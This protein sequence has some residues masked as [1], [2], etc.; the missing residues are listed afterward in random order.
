[1]SRRCILA[2][3]AAWLFPSMPPS[4]ALGAPALASPEPCGSAAPEAPHDLPGAFA[5][6]LDSPTVLHFLTLLAKAPPATQKRVFAAAVAAASTAPEKSAQAA[7]SAGCPDLD[8]LYGAARA[9]YL[10]VNLWQLNDF[11]DA[12]RFQA[13]LGVLATAIAA[14]STNDRLSP[15]DQGA[16]L[17]PFVDLAVGSQSPPEATAGTFT[18]CNRRIR[19]RQG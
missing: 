3:A 1:M 12:A 4:A 19:R 16:A 2:I 17:L 8:A 7:A 13:F 14:L 18:P 5:Y 6:E 9:S 10:T 11:S 15:D